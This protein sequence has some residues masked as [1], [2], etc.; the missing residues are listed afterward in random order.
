[1]ECLCEARGITGSVFG[2]LDDDEVAKWLQWAACF[3]TAT[4]GECN[5]NALALIAAHLKVLES[6]ANFDM[7]SLM[8]GASQGRIRYLPDNHWNR[9]I[10]G[11]LYLGLQVRSSRPALT[12]GFSH[13]VGHW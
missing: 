11:Q 4:R 6:S 7:H 12:S 9:T 13:G 8:S 10:W 2:C 1:M 5:C 3:L